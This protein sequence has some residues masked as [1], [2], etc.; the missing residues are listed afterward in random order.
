MISK[1]D[2][3][4]GRVV[5]AIRDKGVL[6]ET[7]I[8]FFSDN[9][10]QTIGPFNNFGSNYPLKGVSSTFFLNFSIKVC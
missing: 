2:D 7:I 3:G 10:A 4:I 1:L 5:E 9:G 6:N 8:M